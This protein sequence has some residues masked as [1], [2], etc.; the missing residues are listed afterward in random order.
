M[1]LLDIHWLKSPSTMKTR[2]TY[3][4]IRIDMTP[5][6]SIALLLIVFFVWQKALKRPAILGVTI[7]ADCHKYE[8]PEYPRKVICLYLLDKDQVGIMQYW[9]R[10][11][12]PHCVSINFFTS[13]MTSTGSLRSSALA[14]R[15]M[16]S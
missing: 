14:I 3:T 11:I 1:L 12:C 15:T 9:P 13:A 4:P 7:P 16:S 8:S 10:A 2:Q 5:F 6:V